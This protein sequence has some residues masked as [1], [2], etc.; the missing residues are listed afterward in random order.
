M[1]WGLEGRILKNTT[2]HTRAHPT[3]IDNPPREGRDMEKLFD[4]G[5]SQTLDHIKLF[6]KKFKREKRK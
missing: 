3:P 6:K 5:G 2:N 4:F 1:T